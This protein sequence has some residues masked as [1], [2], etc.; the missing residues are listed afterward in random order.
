VLRAVELDAD[1]LAADF[2]GVDQ[3]LQDRVMDVR[4]RARAGP[5]LLQAV[6]ARLLLEN[7]AL[8][9][10]EH[11]LAAELLLELAN[12]AALDAVERLQQGHG[13]EDDNGLLARPNVDLLGRRDVHLP[14]IR[15]EVRNARL[16]IS[17]RLQKTKH[18]VKF[19]ACT[20]KHPRIKI[21][22]LREAYRCRQSKQVYVQ[23]HNCHLL[24][25]V[26]SCSSHRHIN[27]IHVYTS[28]T[29]E[30]QTY[31]SDL[32]LELVGGLPR[33]LDNLS[34]CHYVRSAP[35]NDDIG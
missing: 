9:D 17:K 28:Q 7:A 32:L 11:V 23:G 24:L 19:S 14:Q 22:C 18:L 8:R 20:Y 26:L 1:A 15:L 25:R 13:D 27:H 21:L 30:A 4:E 16:K 35:S 33:G 29:P 31:R 3:V 10:D 34:R 6:L 5:G 12:D 2:C